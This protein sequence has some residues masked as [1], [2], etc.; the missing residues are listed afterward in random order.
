MTGPG[1]FP[2]SWLEQPFRAKRLACLLRGTVDSTVISVGSSRRQSSTTRKQTHHDRRMQSVGKRTS[3][4]LAELLAT[5]Q[6]VLTASGRKA[7]AA[8][9]FHPRWPLRS[10]LCKYRFISESSNRP[11]VDLGFVDQKL[12]LWDP[13]DF[14]SWYHNQIALLTILF[15]D[16]AIISTR[17][18]NS[19]RG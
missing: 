3:R 15:R 8:S 11:A 2:R 19:L 4:R 7:S 9:F 6:I 13:E 10:R 5:T 16:I 14:R 12:Q 1:G 18:N 17:G